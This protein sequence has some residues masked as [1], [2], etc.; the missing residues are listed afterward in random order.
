MGMPGMLKFP[1]TAMV[2]IS[3]RVAT[4]THPKVMPAMANPRPV[5]VSGE[6]SIWL[7]AV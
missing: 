7:L 3:T 5:W 2:T 6:R 4:P 1:V